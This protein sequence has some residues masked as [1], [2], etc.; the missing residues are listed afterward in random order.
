MLVDVRGDHRVDVSG[1]V[2]AVRGAADTPLD[3]LSNLHGRRCAR[4]LRDAKPER[5]RGVRGGY[6]S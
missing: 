4:R 5:H 6:R 1:Y 2:N 3:D